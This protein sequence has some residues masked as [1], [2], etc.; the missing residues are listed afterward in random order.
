MVKDVEIVKVVELC[1]PHC[2]DME[3]GDALFI[4]ICEVLNKKGNIVLNFSDVETITSSFFNAAIGRLFGKYKAEEVESVVSWSNLDDGDTELIRLV[5]S[6][7][8]DHFS[9]GDK[10]QELEGDIVDQTLSDL[11]EK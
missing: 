4:K 11:N 7:A 5:I 10:I 1:G 9:N 3:D 6:N 8:K 2:V